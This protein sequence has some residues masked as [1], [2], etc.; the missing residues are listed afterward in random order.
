MP[1]TP[2]ERE[3]Y[4]AKAHMAA[5]DIA[6]ITRHA[7]PATDAEFIAQVDHVMKHGNSEAK[8]LASVYL[9]RWTHAQDEL[10]MPATA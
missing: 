7:P 5:K 9:A 4:E 1:L 2:K 3:Y 10:L 8:T 6:A